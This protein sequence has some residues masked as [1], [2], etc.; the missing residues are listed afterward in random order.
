MGLPIASILKM[1]TALPIVPNK[2]VAPG[3]PIDK[4][5][6]SGWKPPL[7]IRDEAAV[8]V[9]DVQEVVAGDAEVTN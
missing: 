1:E 8:A 4:I 7:L 6:P 5:L 9:E 2:S 3:F